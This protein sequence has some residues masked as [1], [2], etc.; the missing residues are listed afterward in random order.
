MNNFPNPYPPAIIITMKETM[1]TTLL[2]QI[3]AENKTDKK[4]QKKNRK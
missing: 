2:Q 3:I 4:A 1:N